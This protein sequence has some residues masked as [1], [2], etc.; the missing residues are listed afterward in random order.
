MLFRCGSEVLVLFGMTA[1]LVRAADVVGEHFQAVWQVIRGELSS[2]AVTTKHMSKSCH[3]QQW[4]AQHSHSNILIKAWKAH[5]AF[6]HHQPRLYQA[7]P[8]KSLA[9]L[10]GHQCLARDVVKSKPPCM[11]RSKPRYARTENAE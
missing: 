8:I 6:T 1:V 5:S 7:D 9:S 4:F 2:P 11:P 3:Q 10:N